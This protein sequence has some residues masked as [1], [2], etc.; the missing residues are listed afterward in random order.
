MKKRIIPLVLILMLVA[1]ACKLA[2]G[3]ILSCKL[4][5]PAHYIEAIESQSRGKY[6]DTLPLS[7]VYITVDDYTEGR[8]YYTIHYFPLGSVGMSYAEHDGYNIEKP[9][10]DLS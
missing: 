7:A 4:D 2:A 3:P 6:S 8:V 5:I 1:G 9:L 10:T